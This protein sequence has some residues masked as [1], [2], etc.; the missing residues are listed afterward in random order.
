MD[1]M[2]WIMKVV[3][4]SRASDKGVGRSSRPRDEGGMGDLVSKKCFF[5]PSGLS[6]W[7]KNK[8]GPRPLP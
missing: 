1:K 7:S 5:R 6:V 4:G 8:G 3:P 2:T